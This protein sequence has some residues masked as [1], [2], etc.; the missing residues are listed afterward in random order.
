MGTA[1]KKKKKSRRGTEFKKMDCA[2]HSPHDSD[3]L[4]TVSSF[5]PLI[6]EVTLIF[7]P[8]N[9]DKQ[10]LISVPYISPQL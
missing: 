3:Y 6:H 1:K 4:P 9:K 10:R 5:S 8:I 2:R 7:P